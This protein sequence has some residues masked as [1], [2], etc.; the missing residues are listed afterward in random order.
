MKRAAADACRWADT[1]YNNTTITT[2]AEGSIKGGVEGPVTRHPSPR[3]RHGLRRP[4]FT[5]LTGTFHMRR[6]ILL[7]CNYF[8][9]VCS[10]DVL[11][12]RR[13]M[14][15][16]LI[17]SGGDLDNRMKVLFDALRMPASD[18]E[19]AGATP[20]QGE[21]PFCCLLEDDKL[22]TEIKI[23]TDRLLTPKTDSEG[24]NDVHLI[25]RVTTIPLISPTI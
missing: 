18:D 11:F 19:L 13:D 9:I 25:I 16:D 12:L 5:G 20:Q 22:I 15:G 10:L 4:R 23:T 3:R 24:Q 8:N 2:R 17:K 1:K 21:D 14:P 6:A 7:V